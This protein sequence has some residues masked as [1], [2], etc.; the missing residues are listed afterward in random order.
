M[1][2]RRKLGLWQESEPEADKLQPADIHCYSGATFLIFSP[3]P[4]PLHPKMVTEQD[5]ATEK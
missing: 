2:P 3:A 5:T 1:N 4:A